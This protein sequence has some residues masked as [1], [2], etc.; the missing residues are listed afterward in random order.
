MQDSDD[1]TA[2]RLLATYTN[3]LAGTYIAYA[4]TGNLTSSSDYVRIDGPTV[5]IEFACQNGIVYQGQI[6]Y[7]TVWRDHARDYGGNFYGTYTNVLGTKAAAA[8]Q[9]FSVYPN[10]AAQGRGLQVKLAAPATT[11]RY[12]LRNA[13]GQMIFTK[14]FQGD[15]VQ[16]PT[17]GLPAGTYILS[18]VADGKAPVIHHFVV[19]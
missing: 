6:H 3:E 1:A 16:V 4:G 13:L 2:A 8:A 17:D 19:N 18:L 7:H 15:A 11:A 14:S 9:A 12:T 10:P 5:W